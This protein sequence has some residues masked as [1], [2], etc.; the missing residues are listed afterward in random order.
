MQ[1]IEDNDRRPIAVPERCLQRLDG[2]AEH[3][4]GLSVLAA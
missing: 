1:A 3:W 4:T 2:T